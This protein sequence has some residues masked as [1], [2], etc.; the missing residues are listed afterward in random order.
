M[1]LYLSLFLV[2][3]VLVCLG[4]TCTSIHYMRAQYSQPT[5]PHILLIPAGLSMADNGHAAGRL[6]GVPLQRWVGGWVGGWLDEARGPCATAACMP[7]P[8]RGCFLLLGL[9]RCSACQGQDQPPCLRFVTTTRANLAGCAHAPRPQAQ[10]F[11]PGMPPPA[12][13]DVAARPV[14]QPQ[15]QRHAHEGQLFQ[16]VCGVNGGIPMDTSKC[17]S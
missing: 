8:C 17:V 2:S 6:A 1:K 15:R 14:A 5:K 10:P 11:S 4:S 16:V 12:A 9:Q 13:S 3:S 7:P